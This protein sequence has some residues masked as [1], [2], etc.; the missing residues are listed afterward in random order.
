MSVAYPQE[1]MGS[2][3][4]LVNRFEEYRRVFLRRAPHGS[5]ADALLEVGEFTRGELTQDVY[6]TQTHY[7]CVRLSDDEV[8]EMS[9]ALT[10]AL[11][12]TQSTP[13]GLL[14][15]YFEEE[16]RFLADL[17]DDLD[18]WFVSYGYLNY[19]ADGLVSYRSCASINTSRAALQLM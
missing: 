6:G 17:M 18:R 16:Q 4:L 11:A 3:L 2:T 19:E 7:H 5:E 1:S 12:T 13:E 9:L 8:T 15:D 14:A 10:E